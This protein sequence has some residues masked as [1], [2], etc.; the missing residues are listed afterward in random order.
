M[1]IRVRLRT[2]LFIPLIVI[3]LFDSFENDFSILRI[4]GE[5]L[6][7]KDTNTKFYAMQRYKSDRGKTKRV[8]TVNSPIHSSV[9]DPRRSQN[10]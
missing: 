8:I 6:A 7:E 3:A 1:E 4:Q 9:T 5:V 2:S 10:E